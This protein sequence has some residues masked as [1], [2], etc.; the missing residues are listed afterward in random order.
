M[1]CIFFGYM[2]YLALLVRVLSTNAGTVGQIMILLK[3]SFRNDYIIGSHEAL[4]AL[5]LGNTQT[6]K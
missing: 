4:T 5:Y 2:I 1:C 6:W 3:L